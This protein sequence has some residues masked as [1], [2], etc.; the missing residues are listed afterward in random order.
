MEPLRT[1]A[2]P[3]KVCARCG[4]ALPRPKG[5]ATYVY[6]VGAVGYQSC[7]AC[8]AKWRYLWHDQPALRIRLAGG[9]RGRLFAVLGGL[10]VATVAVVGAVALARSQRWNSAS[11]PATSVPKATASTSPPQTVSKAAVT[12]YNG[13]ASAMYDRRRDFMDW[14]HTSASSTPEYL[15][16]ERVKQYLGD[17]RSEVDELA[18]LDRRS[19]PPAASS[20]VDDLI[21]SDRAFLDDVDLLQNAPFLYSASF[22]DK[23]NQ[24][25]LAV[26][27]ADNDVRRKLG[28]SPVA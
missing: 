12:A 10:V 17:A 4:K 16:D 13:V 9:G 27:T 1:E 2:A 3:R 26:H 25:A 24:E 21:A 14:L 11:T 5:S 7:S 8:G 18:Q 6:G 22:L 23:L 28:L 15:V 20:G 19:W